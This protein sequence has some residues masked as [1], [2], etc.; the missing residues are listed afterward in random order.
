MA[1]V[2]DVV[3]MPPTCISSSSSNGGN[4]GKIF[5]ETI[6]ALQSLP[7]LALIIA[8]THEAGTQQSSACVESFL[9]ALVAFIGEIHPWLCA[10]LA[11]LLAEICEDRASKAGTEQSPPLFHPSPSRPD[12]PEFNSHDTDDGREPPRRPSSTSSVVYG[13]GDADSPN[14]RSQ[15]DDDDEQMQ[16]AVTMSMDSTPPDTTAASSSPAESHVPRA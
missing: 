9:I 10:P 5:S 2:A 8:T 11:K 7:L 1:T 16:L 15:K 14:P 4:T 12:S 13:G 3:P 6:Q